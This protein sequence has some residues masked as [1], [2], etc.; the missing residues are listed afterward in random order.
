[1]L[2]V[3]SKLTEKLI[4]EQL[5]KFL[6]ENS[7]IAD[8][9]FGFMP[10]R[11]TTDA[12]LGKTTVLYNARNKREYAATLYLDL[13]KAFD[14]VD[15]ALLLIKLKGFGLSENTLKWFKNYLESRHQCTLA[16]GKKST[17]GNVPCG[18]PQGSIMGPLLFIIYVNSIITTIENA[19]V[20]M[21]ADDLA[22]TVTGKDVGRIKNILQVETEKIGN[23]CS[24]NKLTVNTDKTVVM[25]NYSTR[26]TPHL[27][28]MD[29]DLLGKR[30][31]RVNTFNYLGVIIDTNL[32]LIPQAKKIINL[33]QVRLAQLKRI[34]PTMDNELSLKIYKL[35]VQPIMDYADFLLDGA[36]GWAIDKLQVLHNYGLRITERIWDARDIG[37]D[38]LMDRCQSER[39]TERRRKHLLAIMYK[40]SR[41]EDNTVRAPRQL[42]GAEKI[43]LKVQPPKQDVFYKSPLY[44]GKEMWDKL[45]KDQQRK[46]SIDSFKADL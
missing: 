10:N 33:M 9:Q 46:I 30:L 32:S 41:V 7:L 29:I 39:L 5:M 14:T 15:H 4:H 25:W 6:L 1:M 40:F 23:W 36:P 12:I 43:R 11:S 37:V 16:N 31:K 21:Y 27:V 42:R 26:N 28:G 8:N 3:F 13:R 19:H 44:R 38:E 17:A 34:R 22:V 20:H 45:D 24:K 18:V 2:N 35:M